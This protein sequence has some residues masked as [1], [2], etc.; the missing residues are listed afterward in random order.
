MLIAAALM[1]VW[2]ANH[3]CTLTEAAVCYLPLLSSEAL[4]WCMQ[5]I[6]KRSVS[7]LLLLAFSW[8]GE[9]IIIIILVIIVILISFLF[10]IKIIIVSKF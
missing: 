8:D 7:L 9:S 6:C 2:F 5:S 4:P 10:G 1:R 3:M